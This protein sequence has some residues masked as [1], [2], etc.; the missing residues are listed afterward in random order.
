M[1]PKRAPLSFPCFAFG[2]DARGPDRALAPCT[3]GNHLGA[4]PAGSLL[5]GG[6]LVLRQAGPLP[7]RCGGIP[8]DRRSEHLRSPL[9]F[10]HFGASTESGQGGAKVTDL[11]AVH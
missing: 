2:L 3:V 1:V 11:R 10:S 8:A 6:Y 7:L 5:Q 9:Y 4:L